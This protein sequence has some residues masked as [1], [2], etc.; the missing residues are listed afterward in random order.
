MITGF[1]ANWEYEKHYFPPAFSFGMN[2][3]LSQDMLVLAPG[4][5][6]IDGE[7][8]FALVEELET[9]PALSRLFENHQKYLDI[10]ILLVGHEMHG[11][12]P[13]LPGQASG[14]EL[15]RNEAPEKDLAFY[16]HPKEAV[17][18]AL[19]PMQYAIYFPGELH[20]PCCT[21]SKPETI[22]KAVLKIRKD[23]LAM[24]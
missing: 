15:V 17:F 21:T 16:T 7:K 19:A 20:C 24:S 9:Q 10:Q 8:I 23:I 18:F 12:F 13:G 1:V 3:V 2:F 4:R 11:F 14:C 22:K 5:H 6:I